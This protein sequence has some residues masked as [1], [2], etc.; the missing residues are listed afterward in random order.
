MSSRKRRMTKGKEGGGRFIDSDDTDVG[1]TRT[2]G[3]NV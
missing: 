3:R 2:E 1:E